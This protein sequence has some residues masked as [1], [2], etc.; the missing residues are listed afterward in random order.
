VCAWA[1]IGHEEAIRCGGLSALPTSLPTSGLTYTSD[2]VRALRIAAAGIES[3][4]GDHHR[5]A[6]DAIVRAAP[7][8]GS[9]MTRLAEIEIESMAEVSA[10]GLRERAFAEA[11]RRG[12]GSTRMSVGFS[13]THSVAGSRR[14]PG[15]AQPLR[16]ASSRRWPSG[17]W[18][19][20]FTRTSGSMP[21][22]SLDACSAVSR[23]SRRTSS[24]RPA[25]GS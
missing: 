12:R 9:H 15:A 7:M 14:D 8:V 25:A 3:L 1:G 24:P 5:A 19:F 18:T 21:T 22:T 20:D 11:S 2:D 17:S 23:G 13:S 4:P 6:L 10:L 16:Q